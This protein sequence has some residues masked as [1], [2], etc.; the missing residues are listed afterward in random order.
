MPDSVTVLAIAG[1]NTVRCPELKCRLKDKVSKQNEYSQPKM[2]MA[3]ASL[4][5][6]SITFDIT[7]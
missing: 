3:L 5:L 6:P 4:C 7:R 1:V 2:I